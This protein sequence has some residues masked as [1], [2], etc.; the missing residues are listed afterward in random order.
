M[1]PFP[2]FSSFSMGDMTALYFKENDIISFAVIPAGMENE[3]PE[4]QK[5]LNDRIACRNISKVAQWN[6]AANW[7]EPLINL[8]IQ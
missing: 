4:H 5:F 6:I 7:I 1:Y 2:L 8:A 3:I